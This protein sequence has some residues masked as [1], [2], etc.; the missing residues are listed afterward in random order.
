M[1]WQVDDDDIVARNFSRPKSRSLQK[2]LFPIEPCC[3]C[4]CD[5]SIK[6]TLAPIKC[7]D[8]YY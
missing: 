2:Q 7:F 5:D 4:P 1:L 6:K 8:P 3:E